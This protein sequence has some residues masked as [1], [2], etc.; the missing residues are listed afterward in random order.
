V[1]KKVIKTND[2]MM[3]IIESINEQKEVKFM[4]VGSS[5]E[6]FFKSEVTDVKLINH[7]NILKKYDV[8]L[9]KYE[10][11]YKLHRIIKIKDHQIIASG[12]NLLSEEV[13]DIDDVIGVVYSFINNDKEIFSSQIS[14]KLKYRLNLLFKPILVR[15]RRRSK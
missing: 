10:N 2:L 4:V 6:P 11:T 7:Q 1:Q 15:L 12:D 3:L 8:I 9:F 14:Y 13:I 5:M